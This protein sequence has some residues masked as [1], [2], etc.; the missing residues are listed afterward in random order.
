MANED[1]ERGDRQRLCIHAVGFNDCQVMVVD[2]EVVVRVASD[3]DKADAVAAVNDSS[4]W[5]RSHV[6]IVSAPFST[7]D[8]DDRQVGGRGLTGITSKTIE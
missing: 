4:A 2:R 3:V 6:R 8:G 1:G 7:L 5:L